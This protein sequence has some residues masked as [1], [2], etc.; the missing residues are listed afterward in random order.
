[1]IK[2]CILYISPHNTEIL[3][4][5]FQRLFG[6]SS[7][8]HLRHPTSMQELDFINKMQIVIISAARHSAALDQDFAHF[9]SRCPSTTV[10]VLAAAQSDNGSQLSALAFDI[11]IDTTEGLIAIGK[12]IQRTEK[13]AYEIE[14]L[15]AAR[16]RY[17][18]VL[19]NLQGCH[20]ICNND[21]DWTMRELS[22]L[23]EQITGYAADD[24]I[25]NKRFT[26]SDLILPQDREKVWLHIQQA[27]LQRKTYNVEYRLKSA[28]GQTKYI[29]ETGFVD[30]SNGDGL[31]EG[32][33][34]DLTHTKRL[35]MHL[36]TVKNIMLLSHNAHS[37]PELIELIKNELAIVFHNCSLNV[38][39]YDRSA[40]SFMVPITAA[41]Q[42]YFKKEAIDKTL[43]SMVVMRKRGLM[44]T[45]SEI[46][47]LKRQGRLKR[48]HEVPNAYIGVP[49]NIDG[50]AHGIISLRNFDNELSL[51]KADYSMIEFI[52]VQI[53]A[54]ML[55]R[56]ATDESILLTDALEQNPEAIL[57]IDTEGHIVYA[58]QHA[59]LNAALPPQKI[60]G[61]LPAILDIEHN[62]VEHVN[63]IWETLKQQKQWEGEF[64]NKNAEGLNYWEY[65]LIKPLKDYQANVTHYI[66]VQ[67]K[68]TERKKAE[69]ELIIARRRAEESDQLKTAFLS[70]MSHEIRTPMNAVIGFAEMLAS[71]QYSPQDHDE[72]VKLILENGHKLL[73]TIDEIIDIAKIEAGQFTIEKTKCSANKILYDNFYI[74]KSLQQKYEKEHLKLISRQNRDNENVFFVSD[75]H[76]INQV[77]NNLI[78]NALKYTFE[79]FIELGYK[80]LREDGTEYICY[81]VK[82]SGTGIS[83][84][85]T[86][87]IFDRFRQASENYMSTQSGNGLGL[88]ISRNVAHLMG[89]DLRVESTVGKGSVFYFM[90]PLKRAKVDQGQVFVPEPRPEVSAAS[91]P[92]KT[93]LIAED[94]DSNFTLLEVMLQKAKVKIHRAYNGKQAVDYVIG[95]NNVDLVL[96]DVRMPLMNGYQATEHIKAFNPKLPVII[97]TAFVMT[98]ER[99]T[100]LAAGCDEY[101]PKPIRATDL[102]RLLKKFL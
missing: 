37:L 23:F 58:N 94:E 70:N 22:P 14:R 93:V 17:K 46:L 95:G 10:S 19:N 90:L 16:R 71:E 59:L 39:F 88:A 30:H 72:F 15:R 21:T 78:E 60:I 13:A 18:S 45:S 41:S 76:R 79:G 6:S 36:A 57:V 49:L 52:A 85:R 63:Q 32:V 29:L 74:L 44:L 47:K 33:L 25:L 100:G 43:D 51:D 11:I 50:K 86:E 28:G 67:E 92:D 8:L 62:S 98:N 101:L 80:L 97:Q 9:M 40:K 31:I 102:Y 89:G 54:V 69:T 77:M 38:A 83:G 27:I 5:Q 7:Y 1:M 24:V 34:I 91:Y 61:S 42:A 73:N 65:A 64:Q 53:A 35:E 96:M 82:D 26:Y 75:A 66:Y 87:I 12:M 68:L 20:F 81:Y 48:D 56:A 55:Q 3:E 99:D 84:D 4:E 2:A